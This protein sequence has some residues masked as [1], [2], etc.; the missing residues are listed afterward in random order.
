MSEDLILYFSGF[1]RIFQYVIAGKYLLRNKKY[2][3]V[4]PV[5]RGDTLIRGEIGCNQTGLWYNKLD[6][7]RQFNGI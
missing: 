7:V 3:S 1:V 6:A 2:F 4:V 5:G